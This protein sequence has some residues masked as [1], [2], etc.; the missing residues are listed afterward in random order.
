MF[1]SRRLS[2]ILAGAGTIAG[3]AGL[4]L[5][6]ASAAE[7]AEGAANLDEIV[8]T[9]RKRE[10]KLQDVPVTVTVI[11]STQLKESGIE[12]IDDIQSEVTNLI[13]SKSQTNTINAVIRGV[14]SFRN[15]NGVGFFYDDIQDFSAYSQR[16]FDVDHV[17]VLKGPQ[18][19]LY[20]GLNIGGAIKYVLKQPEFDWSGEADATAGSYN[21]HTEEVTLT[22]P[23]VGHSLAFRLSAY[24]EHK[25]GYFNNL[26]TG[27][28]LGAI[29]DI[30]GRFA[31]L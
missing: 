18:A 20:G 21:Q 25:D 5:G 23:I 28:K 8:V 7:S 10:E 14:G 4:P 16:L 27:G 30:G 24:A 12:R 31:L 26:Y 15:V 1:K 2:V 29:D 17:E 13:L 22:G 6:A 9:A 11:S 3:G 19:T